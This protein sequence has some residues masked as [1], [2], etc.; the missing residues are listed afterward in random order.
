MRNAN[1]GDG[2][3]SRPA[4]RC[5]AAPAA[6]PG[7]SWAY[8]SARTGRGTACAGPVG[9]RTPM[10]GPTSSRGASGPERLTTR[11]SVPRRWP[12]FAG[13]ELRPKVAPPPPP[14]GGS[15]DALKP[16]AGRETQGLRT[17]PRQGGGVH[18]PGPR[19]RQA[20]AVEST[21]LWLRLPHPKFPDSKG[22]APLGVN[23]HPE[24]EPKR[25]TF[26]PAEPP[27]PAGRIRV[28][29]AELAAQIGQPR[30]EVIRAVARLKAAGA[31]HVMGLN[32][33]EHPALLQLPQPPRQGRH[34]RHQD[35][36]PPV[37]LAAGRHQL[38]SFPGVV[39]DGHGDLLEDFTA[40]A[41]HGRAAAGGSVQAHDLSDQ[42]RFPPPVGSTTKPPKATAWP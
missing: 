30:E 41:D 20:E 42:C 22:D 29:L 13:F 32:G 2:P 40:V 26:L 23:H 31:A 34:H 38:G 28:S 33:Q 7:C 18:C 39:L 11:R 25:G 12:A 27:T 16:G 17:V 6:G 9:F 8:A 35:R 21:V 1:A 5:P 37:G 19:G 24:G 36:R 14:M 15:H 10:A 3:A 4:R